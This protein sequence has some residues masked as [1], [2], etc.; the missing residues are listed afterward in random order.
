MA[1]FLRA[2]WAFSLR[3]RR[4]R[5]SL[6]LSII[7]SFPLSYLDRIRGIDGVRAATSQSW[8]GGIYQDDR[9]QL[10]VF[11]VDAESFAEVYPEY[12]TAEQK[13][14]WLADRAGA[15]VGSQIA[16]RFGWNVGDTV[17]M[18]SNIYSKRDGSNTWDLNISAIYHI[19]DGDNSSVFFHYDYFN[20]ARTFFN[21]E[22]G[23]V[24]LRIDD[25]NR[26]PDIA[27]QID[28]MFANSSAETR[29]TSE[30]AFL[31]GFANQMGNIAAIV[32]VVAAAVF[33]TMLLVTANAMQQ[34]VRERV[35]EIAVLRTLGYSNALVIA[36]VLA[37]GLGITVL[38]GPSFARTSYRLPFSVDPVAF[39]TN[40]DTALGGGTRVAT[41]IVNDQFGTDL[42]LNN[43]IGLEYHGRAL[44][45]RL[46]IDAQV[47]YWQGQTHMAWRLDDPSLRDRPATQ[48]QT[49]LAHEIIDMLSRLAPYASRLESSDALGRLMQVAAAR[50]NDARHQREV[51]EKKGSL[52]DVVR[53]AA[54]LWMGS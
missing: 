40:P 17:P 25:P 3:L 7:Q 27:K 36:L 35:A 45:D 20:E 33:F 24:V 30:S 52:T 1:D 19:E 9:N 42:S 50:R 13:R 12:G 32:T 53:D 10:N 15:F 29:T 5:I 14:A 49:P 34:A 41:G 51:L 21:D 16:E 28:A 18:R 44:D 8:F 43:L 26:G 39:G 46:E 47:S 11:A 48:Q 22:I 37:E 23:W 2:F 4:R 6:C 38:G 54:A 31:Q